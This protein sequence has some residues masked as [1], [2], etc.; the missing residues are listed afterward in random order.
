MKNHRSNAFILGAIVVLILIG[1]LLVESQTKFMS[2]LYDDIVMDSKV[3]YLSCSELPSVDEVTSVVEQHKDII[4]QIERVDPG[5][6]GVYVNSFSC[7]ETAYIV[8]DYASHADR[9][10]IEQIINSET[11]FGIPYELLNR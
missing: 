7:P 6:V 8:I 10:K 5:H 2:R 1:L 4:A 9:L 3:I 11:F